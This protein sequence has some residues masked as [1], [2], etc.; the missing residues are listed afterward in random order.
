MA[1]ILCY[2][3]F[4]GLK[5]GLLTIGDTWR[6]DKGTRWCT[7]TCECGTLTTVRYTNLQ[8]ESVRSCGCLRSSLRGTNYHV[9]EKF[10]RLTIVGPAKKPAWATDNSSYSISW[11]AVDCDCGTKGHIA[12]LGNVITGRSKSCGCLLHESRV[13]P[14]NLKHG[15][16]KTPIYFFWA[17]LSG[18]GLLDETWKTF[19]A[20]L[21]D[22][23]PRPEGYSLYRR[24]NT[25]LYS[26][27]N[28]P[29]GWVPRRIASRAG[30]RARLIT[31]KGETKTLAEW[32]TIAGVSRQCIQ[33]WLDDSISVRAGY[34]PRPRSE[35]DIHNF[36]Y[37][38][39]TNEN[40][41]RIS[42]RV[43]PKQRTT[44][45]GGKKRGPKGSRSVRIAPGAMAEPAP[46]DSAPRR[47]RSQEW[48]TRQ[49]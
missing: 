44:E 39:R 49:D 18:K 48:P 27:E 22:V 23:G 11:V 7:C 37:A 34:K 32:A 36:I 47:L 25:K 30:R 45:N 26:K 5:F 2:E 21:A 1:K 6:D 31:V 35:D 16:S 43:E 12:R 14:R 41:E 9:G 46:R 42:A 28:C 38:A 20:F 10:E 19:D 40:G 4:I 15:M 8:Q 24:D 17:N 3:D 33:Q 29:D 13:T